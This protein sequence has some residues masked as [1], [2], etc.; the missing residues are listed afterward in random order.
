MILHTPCPKH[1]QR[2]PHRTAGKLRLPLLIQT[3]R[4]HQKSKDLTH[5][6]LQ[7]AP[8][9]QSRSSSLCSHATEPGMRRICQNKGLD[10]RLSF[11]FTQMHALFTLFS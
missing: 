2:L 8:G 11:L 4:P 3:A 5:I 10:R 6:F 9:P 1:K 7:L